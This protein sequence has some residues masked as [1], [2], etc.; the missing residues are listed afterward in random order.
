MKPRTLL[1]F[2]RSKRIRLNISGFFPMA[3]VG[4]ATLASCLRDEGYPVDLLDVEGSG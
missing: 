2:P 1:V 4:I 3:P